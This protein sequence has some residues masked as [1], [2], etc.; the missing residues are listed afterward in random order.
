MK[1]EDFVN[2]AFPYLVRAENVLEMINGLQEN[3]VE[4][5]V[6]SSVLVYQ[7]QPNSITEI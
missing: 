6:P 7:H 4:V 2:S 5:A 1:I 3:H